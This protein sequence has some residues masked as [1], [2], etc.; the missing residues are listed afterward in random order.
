MEPG[1][2]LSPQDR[3][4]T[5]SLLGVNELADEQL[6]NIAGGGSFTIAGTA[7]NLTID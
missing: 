2:D 5:E 6:E 4:A 1:T 7:P 3:A